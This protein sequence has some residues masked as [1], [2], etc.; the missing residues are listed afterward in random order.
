[1]KHICL[2]RIA[3]DHGDVDRKPDS[4]VRAHGRIHRNEA[5]LQRLGKVGLVADRAVKDRLAVFMLPDLEERHIPL[6]PDK[7]TSPIDHVQRHRLAA[8]LATEEEAEVKGEVLLLERLAFHG[9]DLA[10]CPAYQLGCA[11]QSGDIPPLFDL[12]AI[13]VIQAPGQQANDRMR[14]T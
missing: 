10:D 13:R 8:D 3:A 7:V 14:K 9:T 11:E 1:M 4:E 12:T 2:E 6:T 5:N